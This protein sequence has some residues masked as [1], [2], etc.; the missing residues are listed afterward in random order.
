MFYLLISVW[1]R[2]CAVVSDLICFFFPALRRKTRIIYANYVKGY[3]IQPTIWKRFFCWFIR[4]FCPGDACLGQMVPKRSCIFQLKSLK[5]FIFFHISIT[6]SVQELLFVVGWM[7]GCTDRSLGITPS[8]EIKAILRLWQLYQWQQHQI[9]SAVEAASPARGRM[10]ALFPPSF[11][12]SV[13][14][15]IW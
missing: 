10:T 1:K 5:K 6:T 11:W 12:I 8:V 15:I 9:E 13:L 7:Q 14:I 4:F 3:F 2:W